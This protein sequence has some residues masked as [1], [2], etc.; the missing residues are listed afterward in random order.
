VVRRF[1]AFGPGIEMM[2]TVFCTTLV[3]VLVG[4]RTPTRIGT[5]WRPAAIDQKS[6]LVVAMWIK[7]DQD[8]RPVAVTEDYG[9]L[10]LWTENEKR[11]FLFSNK[12]GEYCGTTDFESFLVSLSKMP[13]D[14]TIEWVDTCTVSR[15]RK[16]PKRAHQRLA[17]VLADGNRRTVAPFRACY[18]ESQGLRYPETGPSAP[19]DATRR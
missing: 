17:A 8:D 5:T 18:C 9:M 11:F 3:V 6:G 14:I 2:K 1:A 16:M 12:S 15:S 4:C 13:K 7:Q 10:I 19:A